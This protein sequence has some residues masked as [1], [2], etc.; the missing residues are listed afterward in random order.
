[1]ARLQCEREERERER[2]F[3]LRREL[4][5]RKQELEIRKHELEIRKLE[6]DTAVRMRQLELQ[7]AVVGDSAVT[8]SGPAASFDVQPLPRCSLFPGAP[9]LQSRIPYRTGRGRQ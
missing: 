4:E 6:A 2:E 5:S 1:M 7:A 8:P 3:Q 9:T